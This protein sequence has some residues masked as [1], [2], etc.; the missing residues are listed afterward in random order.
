MA[1]LTMLK[2]FLVAK[3][4]VKVG[5]FGSFEEWTGPRGRL[6]RLAGRA[7]RDRRGR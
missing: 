3:P 2:A 6:S 5:A 4:K 7:R 1:A